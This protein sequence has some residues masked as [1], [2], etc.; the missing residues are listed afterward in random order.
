M[1]RMGRIG[2]MEVAGFDRPHPAPQPVGEKTFCRHSGESRNPGQGRRVRR[3]PLTGRDA[4]PTEAPHNNSL[5]VG[6]GEETVIRRE[7]N[8]SISATARSISR[9]VSSLGGSPNSN[10][11]AYTVIK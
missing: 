7:R 8:C 5:P 9:R 2:P 4:C 6:E 10:D 1:G 3:R 11:L